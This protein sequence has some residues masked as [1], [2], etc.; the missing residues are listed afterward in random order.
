[1]FRSDDEGRR[2][3]HDSESRNAIT[4]TAKLAPDTDTFHTASHPWHPS[5][6]ATTAPR[7]NIKPVHS[8]PT[9]AARITQYQ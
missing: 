7:A 3:D 8:G 4:T 1:M 9:T 2:G 6:T 5:K